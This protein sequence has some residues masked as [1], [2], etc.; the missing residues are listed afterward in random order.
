MYLIQILLP[1]YTNQGEKF[2]NYMYINVK[3][4]LTQIFGGVTMYTRSPATGLWKEDGKI[5]HDEII[6]FEVMIEEIKKSYWDTLKHRLEHMFEQ[7]VI[8]IR[9]THFELI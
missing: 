6:L 3:E 5:I 2:E 4:E 1:L 8:I 9:A 7:E